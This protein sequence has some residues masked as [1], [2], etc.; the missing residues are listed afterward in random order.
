MNIA[1]SKESDKN[2]LDL[3]EGSLVGGYIV[4]KI[5]KLDEIAS[6]LYE[7][8]HIK[9]GAKHIHISNND[10]ENT[11]AV[12]FKTVPSDSTGV[13]HILEHTALCGSAKFNVRD[14]FFSMLKRS[15]N[16]FMNAFT[17]SDWTMYPFSTQNK[18]DYFNLM[19]VYMDATFFPNL[20]ELS[21][22][23]EGHRLEFEPV[24]NPDKNGKAEKLVYK[25]IVYNEMKGA[26]SSPD[27]VMVRS[28][29]S[30]LYPSTTY[31]FNSGG[32]PEDIPKLTWEEL[33]AFHKRHYHPSN[34]FFYTY[35]NL[36]IADS[37][38]FIEKTILDKFSKIDPNTKVPA[39]KRWTEPKK[40]TDNYPLSKD[41]DPLKKYQVA[42]AWL[43]CD[44]NDTFD[45]L[46]LSILE[47]VILGNSASPLYKALI[48]S[49]LGSSLSDGTGYDADN[50]DTMFSCGLKD[51]EKSSVNKVEK[52]IFDVF[53]DLYTN[54]IDQELVNSAIHQI[55]FY[56]KEVTNSPYPYG[57]KLLLRMSGSW[58]HGGIPSRILQFDTDLKRLNT[59]LSKG[60][61][62]ES[63]IK[64][65]FIDNT[66][67]VLFTLIPDQEMSKKESK[68]VELEL[69]NIKDKMTDDDLELIRKDTI[70]LKTLQES[71]ED[72]SSL[73]TL[74]L[75]DV[76]TEIKTV[77]ESLEY[78]NISS[79]C[80]N[81]PTSGILY[82]SAVA[83]IAS[84][85]EN[86]IPL[87]PFFCTAFSRI[88]T[89]KRDYVKLARFLDAHTGG[90]GLSSHVS[91]SFDK[92]GTCYP[93]V[94][95]NGKCLHRNV[96]A[97]FE[98]TQELISEYDYSELGRLKTLLLEYKAGI[99][100][101]I[102]HNGH[103]YA[104]S[105]SSRNFSQ[106]C[107]LNEIWHGVHQFQYIKKLTKDFDNPDIVNKKLKSI[108]ND[109]KAIADHVFVKDNF[110]TALIGDDSSIC[111]S[112]SAVESI[113]KSLKPVLNNKP[114]ALISPESF[115]P[116]EGWIIDTSVFFVASTF[117][118]VRMEHK[119]SPCLAVISR[120]LRS[121]YLHR[122]IR[123]KGGAYGGFAMYNMEDG[124]F[125]FASY[126][127]PHIVKTLTVYKNAAS[128]IRSGDFKDVDI[129]EAILQVCSDID[130]P[131]T[132]GPSARKAFYRT[133]I[134][135]T[136]EMRKKFKENLLSVT[137][138]QVIN[139]AEKYFS[140][141]NSNTSALYS[142]KQLGI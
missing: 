80:Y 33:K 48:D 136:D 100:S 39:Q 60:G 70:L 135:L 129:K 46:V 57:I 32:D 21:F 102:V 16:T 126:R 97:L 124:L 23:Q 49:E 95:I 11:F 140:I 127:D 2:S 8:E 55:E 37:L 5:T 103:K 117:K 99:E 85:P 110:K 83:N 77:N 94:A 19:D 137:R 132:P 38:D 36:P 122:E 108:S 15:L 3:K 114:I 13:A 87:V 64:K 62:L 78:S 109:L 75:D 25:G 10:K 89:S 113:L 107:L 58:F 112:A 34:A 54:G 106:S 67:R 121:I 141:D 138:E 17:A 1:K 22:K 45:V 111:D 90:L 7:F 43:L 51:V 61:F 26:M 29:Q 105:L 63:V 69:E 40:I 42:V 142:H 50:R 104:I 96:G 125:S 71:E 91:T 59:E 120:I 79:K 131:D 31:N 56:Q 88:G 73:P 41:K 53:N 65:Q 116:V 9:T 74:G 82:F 92:N 84:L 98:I 118:V 86:L 12:A 44:I 66:H 47:H 4:E 28:L 115:I 72:I 101:T 27:Q 139:T 81:Q 24:I 35:G 18:K 14:P 52:I 6:I 133:I 134:S 68:R 119:D 93:F 30:S 20:N 123:E 130:K 76:P 128:F